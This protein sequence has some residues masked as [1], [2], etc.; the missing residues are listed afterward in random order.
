ML[1]RTNA[2]INRRGRALAT[3]RDT[4]LRAATKA[5]IRQTGEMALKKIEAVEDSVILDDSIPPGTPGP[6]SLQE[7]GRA[8]GL[9][10]DLPPLTDY[11]DGTLVE[12]TPFGGLAT[13][14]YTPDVSKVF[15]GLPRVEHTVRI[16]H[17]DRWGLES[18]WSTPVSGTPGPNV[19]DEIAENVRIEAESINGT[20]ALA[21]LPTIPESKLADITSADKL[22]NATLL[23]LQNAKA[24]AS[25]Y[26]GFQNVVGANMLAAWTVAAGRAIIGAATIDRALI[27]DAAIST[28]KIDAAAITT[29]KIADAAITNAKINS[30][31]ADKILAGSLVAS[32]SV[33]SGQIAAGGALMNEGGITLAEISNEIGLSYQNNPGSWI[34]PRLTPNS[35]PSPFGGYG[36]FNDSTNNSR[37]SLITGTGVRNANRTGAVRL[38]ATDGDSAGRNATNSAMLSVISGSSNVAGDSGTVQIDADT[39]MTG[40]AK[41]R[42]GLNVERGNVVIDAGSLFFNQVA[43]L[44]PQREINPVTLAAG[45]VIRN[46]GND[47]SAIPRYVFAQYVFG[48]FYRPMVD[49]VAGFTV[50]ATNGE[51]QIVNNNTG[52][53]TVR[54]VAFF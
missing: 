17:R 19:M 7:L 2:A 34:T 16:K 15:T 46:I 14:H 35:P 41:I 54:A 20:L 11:V 48:G 9:S 6:P 51:M 36:F 26:A 3:E 42:T 53:R 43:R 47:V 28:A 12:L 31:S 13:T 8:L 37:G 1:E 10:W 40:F 33:T 25:G 38:F 24:N 29:A 21:N 32:V 50:A 49:G 4:A 39:I 44:A 23:V 18:G 22:V 27:A 45:A 30:L 52:S 5:G